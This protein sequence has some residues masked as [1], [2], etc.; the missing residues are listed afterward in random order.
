M[1]F[2]TTVFSKPSTPVWR[3]RKISA[4]PPTA[5]RS[6]KRYLPYCCSRICCPR[7]RKGGA[8]YL[9]PRR[10]QSVCVDFRHGRG[11]GSPTGRRVDDKLQE[12]EQRFERLT[13]DLGNPEVI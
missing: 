5:M 6:N 3:A 12:I 2:S 11:Y 10:K 4:I 7:P 13:A 1:R 8:F 9:F